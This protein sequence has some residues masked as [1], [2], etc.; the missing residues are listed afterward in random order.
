MQILNIFEQHL[1]SDSETSINK[2]FINFLKTTSEANLGQFYNLA[3]R[4]K[5]T[6]Y[7]LRQSHFRHSK[8]PGS[9]FKSC[10]FIMC[11]FEDCNFA[12]S[13]FLHTKFKKCVFKNCLFEDCKFSNCSFGYSKIEDCSFLYST[14]PGTSLRH[15]KRV[16]SLITK[17]QFRGTDI[18]KMALRIIKGQAKSSYKNLQIPIELWDKISSLAKDVRIKTNPLALELLEKA[19]INMAINGD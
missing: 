17:S 15:A 10:E 16:E 9:E 12:Q 8:L 19:Y 6:S 14:F 11:E 1:Y 18:E 3:M 13:E 4:L 2:T 5:L 7:T